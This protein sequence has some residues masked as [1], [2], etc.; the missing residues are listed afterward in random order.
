MP[1][2]LGGTSYGRGVLAAPRWQMPHRTAALTWTFLIALPSAGFLALVSPFLARESS[3]HIRV[4]IYL[5]AAPH[6]NQHN[7]FDDHSACRPGHHGGAFFGDD[8]SD[9][10]HIMY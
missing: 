8:R 1:A 2:E 9:G 6:V 5:P 4:S 3:P 7:A 10:P